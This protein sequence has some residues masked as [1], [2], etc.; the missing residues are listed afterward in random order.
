MPSMQPSAH[1]SLVVD[2]GLPKYYD[3]AVAIPSPVFETLARTARENHVFL[4]LGI[5]EKEGGTPYYTAFL[6]YRDGMLPVQSQLI[7]TAAER[8]IWGRGSGDGLIVADSAIGKVGG[9]I[10]W[11]NYMPAARLAL[12]HK[13][14]EYV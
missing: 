8:L 14:I 9:L 6:L 1:E 11:E 3:A 2:S 13:G 7:P 4:S 5:V 12:Y 10:C